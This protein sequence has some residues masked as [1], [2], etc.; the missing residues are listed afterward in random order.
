M[1]TIRD[2]WQ[3][4]MTHPQQSVSYSLAQ[5]LP[6]FFGLWL[7][8]FDS[9]FGGEAD[10]ALLYRGTT[11]HFANVSP[12][13]AYDNSYMRCDDVLFFYNSTLCV[14]TDRDGK[15]FFP[16][17]GEPVEVEGGNTDIS[18]PAVWPLQ[19]RG[20]QDSACIGSHMLLNKT[21]MTQPA[22]IEPTF[23]FVALNAGE[24]AETGRRVA[25]GLNG[26]TSDVLSFLNRIHTPLLFSY[27]QYHLLQFS[28]TRQIQ[29]DGS[30]QLEYL[31]GQTQH[32]ALSEPFLAEQYDSILNDTSPGG[33]LESAADHALLLRLR[34]HSEVVYKTQQ[35]CF[36]P[37]T[38]L[39]QEIRQIRSYTLTNFLSDVG[40][41][42]RAQTTHTA[43][44]A[45]SA[46]ASQL[47]AQCMSGPLSFE[48]SSP[49]ALCPVLSLSPCC[50]PPVVN[51]CR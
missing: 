7:V 21:R 16:A 6:A 26:H 31:F 46:S 43:C 1:Y 25:D 10:S 5:T 33:S 2:K 37:A 34:N 50:A 40:Q 47:A 11:F 45:S 18:D 41:S 28:A 29:L 20:Q 32:L 42:A 48:C 27:Q 13:T 24:V 51:A 36:V 17:T 39:V 35:I 9:S 22:F 44:S 19:F 30:S 14:P 49:S 3:F 4:D 8:Y 15:R 38:F 12:R 23:G